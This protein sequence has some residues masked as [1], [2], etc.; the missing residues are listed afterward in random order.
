MKQVKHYHKTLFIIVLSTLLLQSC[1]FFK[2]K[3]DPLV[4][5]QKEMDALLQEKKI[6]FYK[7]V[8]ITLRSSGSNA[9]E[10]PEF[11]KARDAMWASLETVVHAADT[12][13]GKHVLDAGKELLNN[14]KAF[15]NAQAIILKRDE[16]VYPTILEN[17]LR[18]DVRYAN[19]VGA[20]TFFVNKYSASVEHVFLA[21]IATA[22]QK[23]PLAIT[24]YETSLVKENDIKLPD[25]YLLHYLNK[26]I[27]CIKG[28]W[29]YNGEKAF[30][31]YTSY[32][33]KNK[34]ALG[35]T[36][37]NFDN[38]N[39][40]NSEN[41]THSYHGLGML[42][43]ALIKEKLGKTPESI[44]CLES[45]LKEDASYMGADKQ[46]TDFLLLYVAIRKKDYDKARKICDDINNDPAADPDVK[47]M[48]SGLSKNIDNK[49]FDDVNN[50]L[51]GDMVARFSVAV[52][53]VKEL[54]KL[55]LWNMLS[56]SK[57]G[58]I[59]VDAQ[60]RDD[61]GIINTDKAKEKATSIWKKLF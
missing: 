46:V 60:N 37:S 50:A 35:K 8:K 43:G 48:A 23:A 14:T 9:T 33:D 10:D 42:C 53:L 22:S 20:K 25:M 11:I 27:N 54:Q 19:N 1:K 24:L 3:E 49:S 12:I 7:T 5:E 17:V 34:L 13:D 28:K 39:T 59:I 16:D 47:K 15:N 58:D 56:N 30:D 61:N 26:Q 18:N 36:L 57:Q 38:T 4:K 29:Y 51:D 55:D 41:I 2:K 52:M 21:S 6:A 45:F 31:T 44:N 40:L 32:F